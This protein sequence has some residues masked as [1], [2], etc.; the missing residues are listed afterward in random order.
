MKCLKLAA[1]IATLLSAVAWQPLSGAERGKPAKIRVLLTVGGHGFEEQPFY[2]MLNSIADIQ[3]TKI[4]L[5]RDAGMLKPGLEKQYDVILRYDMVGA[6]KPEQQEAFLQLLHR[7][8][9]LFSLHH[10]MGAHPDWPEYPKIIGGKFFIKPGE[11]G[12]VKYKQSGWDHDQDLAVTVTDKEH[13]ITKGLEDFQ[14][15]DEAY[16][17]YWTD[18]KAKVLLKTDHP[19]NDPEV[20][21]VTSYGKSRVFYLMLGHDSR[22]YNHAA[23]RRLL[24][25]GIRWAAGR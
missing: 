9:G 12:G 4:E 6:I 15:H 21:W 17:G 11:I 25:Q 14:I 10:N 24:A 5:P 22:A 2:A 7:G 1:S 8:I 13:P 23:F 18:P 19:K 3:W 20:A 16:S